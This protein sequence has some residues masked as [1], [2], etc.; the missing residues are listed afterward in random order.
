MSEPQVT[1]ISEFQPAIEFRPIDEPLT[2][3]EKFTLAAMQGFCGNSDYAGAKY[4]V[5]ASM[6]R[7][8]ADATIAELEAHP[9]P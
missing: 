7:K 5:L 3:R 2:K 8:Q 9:N 4:E 1:V 6:A